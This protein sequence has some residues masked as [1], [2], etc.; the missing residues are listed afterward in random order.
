MTSR[1]SLPSSLPT[2]ALSSR[3]SSSPRWS[4]A[5][6]WPGSATRS[7]NPPYFDFLSQPSTWARGTTHSKTR[8]INTKSSLGGRI[9]GSS[10][11]RVRSRFSLL[12]L[13]PGWFSNIYSHRNGCAPA[14]LLFWISEY[15]HGKYFTD[16]NIYQ[17]DFI[18]SDLSMSQGACQC[19][20]L[21]WI[22]KP[23]PSDFFLG[24]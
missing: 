14:N 21:L 9:R 19:K 15:Q 22:K 23:F 13:P 3:A 20:D 10:L 24:Y 12:V 2:L 11:F 7:A 16:G 4:W 1:L 5:I 17:V 8:R 18:H 6:F